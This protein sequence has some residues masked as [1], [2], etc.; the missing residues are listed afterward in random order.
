MSA[1]TAASWS[2]SA[3]ARSAVATG[4]P[5][6]TRARP[7]RKVPGRSN[8][9]PTGS[10]ER[11]QPGLGLA[12]SL[13]ED[14]DRLATPER[15]DRPGEQGGVALRAERLVGGGVLAAL[16]RDG[17]DRPLPPAPRRVPEERRLGDRDQAPGQR[18]QRQTGIVTT[19]R[20]EQRGWYEPA[21]R[22]VAG[23]VVDDIIDWAPVPYSLLRQD[24]VVATLMVLAAESV[25]TGKRSPDYWE[26]ERR[27]LAGE[28]EAVMRESLDRVRQALPL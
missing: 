2:P 3:E 4:L 27:W 20:P 15:L 14:Q 19:F 25:K 16:G 12:H 5:I 11:H 24:R 13:G 9:S 26:A 6:S 8:S 21:R 1:R 10:T 22:D 7:V 28:G 23:Q 18:G 17:A